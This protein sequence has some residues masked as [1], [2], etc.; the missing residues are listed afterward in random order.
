MHQYGQISK[1]VKQK[2]DSRTQ[3]LIT[4]PYIKSEKYSKTQGYL[5]VI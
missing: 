3:N 5:W 4:S 2:K 1:N